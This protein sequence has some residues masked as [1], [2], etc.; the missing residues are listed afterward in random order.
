MIGIVYARALL[1]PRRTYRSR[2]GVRFGSA[3]S[4]TAWVA[5][6]YVR[7]CAVTTEHTSIGTLAPAAHPRP[8]WSA[9]AGRPQLRQPPPYDAAQ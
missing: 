1:A 2:A 4:P 9:S 3:P 7:P 8:P 6:L 5:T